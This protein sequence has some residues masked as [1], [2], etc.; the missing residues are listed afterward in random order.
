MSGVVCGPCMAVCECAIHHTRVHAWMD[1]VFCLCGQTAL[2]T[3]CVCD[4]WM[5][6]WRRGR[7]G[8]AA[9]AVFVVCVVMLHVLIG[10]LFL[11]C[12]LCV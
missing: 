10:Q 4:G 9:A 1:G 2:A 11:F 8:W 12:H 7:W 6:G 5:N 3:K